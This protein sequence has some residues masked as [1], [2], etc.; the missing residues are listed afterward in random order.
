M[1]R[2]SDNPCKKNIYLFFHFLLDIYP[3][4]RVIYGFFSK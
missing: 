3:A 4:K 1:N 2:P